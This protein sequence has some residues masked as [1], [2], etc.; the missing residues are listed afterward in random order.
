MNRRHLGGAKKLRTL[1][2]EPGSQAWERALLSVERPFLQKG[3]RKRKFL[4]LLPARRQGVEYF[5][6]LQTQVAMLRLANP[7]TRN[8]TRDHLISARSTVR[9][10]AN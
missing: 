1:G 6:R 7:A 9:C 4:L 10:S 5:S 3:G 8:R 2:V